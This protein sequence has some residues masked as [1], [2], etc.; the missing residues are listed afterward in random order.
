MYL[1]PEK[2]TP[3]DLVATDVPPFFISFFLS[4]DD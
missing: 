3:E 2:K 4:E 1:D